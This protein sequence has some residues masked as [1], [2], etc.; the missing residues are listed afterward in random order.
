[1]AP[2]SPDEYAQMERLMAALLPHCDPAEE[3]A[4]LALH[5]KL[6]TIFEA[7]SE[8]CTSRSRLKALQSQT[9]R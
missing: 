4:L 3:A 7:Q 6:E 5:N 8:L 2:I 9:A 1:M